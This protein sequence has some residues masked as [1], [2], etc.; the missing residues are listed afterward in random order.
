V[1]DLLSRSTRQLAETLASDEGAL[2]LARM[3][4]LALAAARVP[5]AERPDGG[6]RLGIW[7]PIARDDGAIEFARAADTSG[8]WRYWA[9]IDRIP[10]KIGPRVVL[11][12]ESVARAY[13]FD[14]AVTLAGMLQQSLGVE[15]VDLARTDLVAPQLPPLFDALPALEPDAVVLFAGNN[16]SSV[17]LELEDLD[18][19]SRAIR[20]GGF[21]RCRAMF[22]DTLIRGRAR[23]TLE[24]IA[25]R[26]ENTPLVVVVPEFNL[27]DWRSEPGVVVPVV[28]DVERWLALAAERRAAE[29]IAIDDGASPVSQQ[30]AAAQAL[31]RNDVAE[32][33]Q[34]LEAAR[35]A[36]CGLMVS[37]SP[38]C[39]R[40]VQDELRAAA[41]RPG[42]RLVDLPRLFGPL[43]DRHLFLD[44]CHL[45]GEGLQRATAAIAD[46][47]A[48]ILNVAPGVPAETEPRIAARA[49]LLAAVHNA[50]YGQPAEIVGYHARRANQLDPGIRGLMAAVA[51]MVCRNVQPWLTRAWEVLRTEP[52]VWRYLG[53]PEIQ[54]APRVVDVALADALAEAADLG[55][56]VDQ[57]LVEESA[58]IP[59]DLLAPRHRAATF[60]EAVGQGIGPQLGFVRVTAPTSRFLVVRPVAQELT[61]RITLR[62]SGRVSV[63]VNDVRVAEIPGQADWETCQVRLPLTAGRNVVELRWPPPAAEIEPA[64]ERAARRM[65]RALYP[66]PLAAFGELHGFTAS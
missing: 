39:P 19:L 8:E 57:L 34:H 31:E 28:A 58:S 14:P 21:T 64:L 56:L 33:R 3:Q 43:P 54:R 42:V 55:G 62:A 11:V 36:L 29:M 41:D 37:H 35:D 6:L 26:L 20:E 15:V 22:V 61:G 4:R 60:R 63:I 32:A 5:P 7:D 27:L 12:G 18:T 65:E 59:L 49:H 9:D 51:E 52:Q 23:A 50:H 47:L 10:R 48:P 40:V 13:L 53:A 1:N 17:L 16:W 24:Q 66:E 44:Y 46:A 25:D 38:R 2:T 45:T 30:I